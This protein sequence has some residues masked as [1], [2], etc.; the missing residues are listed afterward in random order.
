MQICFCFE[1][2]RFEDR[3]DSMLEAGARMNE[4]VAGHKDKITAIVKFAQES[5]NQINHARVS[6]KFPPPSGGRKASL[7]KA[8]LFCYKLRNSY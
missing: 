7:T 1:A 8:Q 4:L 2:R 6:R 3:F 5:R